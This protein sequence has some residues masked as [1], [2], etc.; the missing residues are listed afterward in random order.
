MGL[1]LDPPGAATLRRVVTGGLA[2]VSY[3]VRL[4]RATAFWGTIL[5]PPVI[6]GGLAT[7]LATSAPV[8]LPALVALNVLCILLGRRYRPDE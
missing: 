6:V 2:C 5:L 7:D 8:R 1:G 3:A 4:C